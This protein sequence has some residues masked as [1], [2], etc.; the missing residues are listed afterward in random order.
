MMAAQIIFSL[1]KIQEKSKVLAKIADKYQ[2]NLLAAVKA[3]KHILNTIQD[4]IQ[5]FDIS[6]SQ[7]FALT[8]AKGFYFITNCPLDDLD[9][10]QQ[11]QKTHYLISCNSLYYFQEI[12]K[13]KLPFVLRLRSTNLLEDPQ[14]PGSR[15]GLTKAQ[16]LGLKEQLQENC[17]FS[18]FHFHHGSEKNSIATYQTVITVIKELIR[19]LS[20]KKELTINLGGGFA[21]LTIQEI[22]VI[23]K[24]ARHE[25]GEHKVYVEPGRYFTEGTGSCFG[26]VI[27]MQEDK[28]NLIV[29]L[30]VSRECHLKWSRIDKIQI[31]KEGKSPYKKRS[32]RMTFYGNTCYENDIIGISNFEEYSEIGIGDTVVLSNISGYSLAWNTSFNGIPRINFELK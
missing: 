6:N 2:V 23:L 7:E 32:K 9:F 24:H 16:V 13:K 14:Q 27:D 17:D 29:T 20:I 5:G 12:S 10:V 30:N 4:N 15:F 1:K 21:S 11:M 19:D 25:L 31:L 8:D 28:D 26:Q 3:S 18:G 22:E